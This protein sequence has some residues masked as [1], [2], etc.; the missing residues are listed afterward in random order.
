MLFVIKVLFVLY[1]FVKRF[2]V[3]FEVCVIFY[4]DF[5]FINNLLFI[6]IEKMYLFVKL[7]ML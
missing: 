6:N 4:I 7:E 2:R 5:F 1:I 3:F